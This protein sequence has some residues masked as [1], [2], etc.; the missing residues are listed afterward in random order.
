MAPVKLQGPLVQTRSDTPSLLY[1]AYGSNMSSPRLRSR[2]AS[3]HAI[4]VACLPAHDLRFHKH[5]RDG[6]A[7]CDA[8]HTG[9]ERDVV[10]GVVFS[11]DAAEKP[12]LDVCEGLGNGYSEKT[13]IVNGARGTHYLAFTYCATR[14][15]A[16]LQPY[17]WYKEH[18]LRGALEHGLGDAYI[19]AIRGIESIADP[20]IDNH[21][22]ELAIYHE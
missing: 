16:S 4:A 1:F 6:S 15:D 19:A 5:G 13:V 20:V 10:Q 22:R 18:V 2:V 17:H 9:L 14:T 12:C 21:Q 3:A 11:I 7:K 8:C